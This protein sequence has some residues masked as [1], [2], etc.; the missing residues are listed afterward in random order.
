MFVTELTSQLERSALNTDAA[1]NIQYMFS[2]E[3]VSH[4]EMSVLNA[5]A[6]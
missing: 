2:T 1:A 4:P 3:L 5:D 6:D